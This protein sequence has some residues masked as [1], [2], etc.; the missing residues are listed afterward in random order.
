[1]DISVTQRIREL[2][3]AK[4]ETDTSFSKKI[5]ISQ[6]TLSC[7]M[8]S[9]KGVSM[10]V[11]L[12]TLE[13]YPEVS[14]EWLMRGKGSMDIVDDLPWMEG[15]E[16]EKEKD[17]HASLAKAIAQ[18][19]VHKMEVMKLQ[20]Q[21]EYLE[22]RNDALVVSNRMLQDELNKYQEREE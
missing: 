10:D 12:A 7:Q 22:E 1:M 21:K 3:K 6:S 17:I 20:A 5:G 8:R 11:L 9:V 18:M 2:I 19:E 16:T 4:G 15:D 13:T 14:S